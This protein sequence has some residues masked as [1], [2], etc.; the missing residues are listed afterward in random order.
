MKLSKI[1]KH[2]GIEANLRYSLHLIEPDLTVA[3]DITGAKLLNLI[4][5]KS[6][7]SYQYWLAVYDNTI[8]DTD[9]FPEILETTNLEEWLF[10]NFN[11]ENIDKIIAGIS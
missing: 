6:L 10:D 2:Y 11:E 9:G 1:Y 7:I 5:E 4:K 3:S 8:R